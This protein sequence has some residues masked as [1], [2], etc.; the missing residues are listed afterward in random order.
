M[1][2]HIDDAY[3][4]GLPSE[5]AKMMAHLKKSVEVL[6]I[7]R[8][9]DHLGVSYSLQRDEIGWYYECEM[10]KY[11][12]KT[13]AEYEHDMKKTLQEHPTPAARGSILSKLGEEEAADRVDQFHKYIGRVLYAVLKVLLD[14]DN[15]IRD[16]TCHMT[17][18]GKEHWK[19]L[20]HL[21][22]YLKHHYRPMKF[23]APKELRAVA[24]FDG[25][26]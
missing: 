19:A 2:F 21:L 10:S 4:T 20:E 17:A 24:M 26:W 12:K 11:I 18:P 15:A 5:V 9:Q 13:I 23:R 6:E 16:M 3:C 14:C 7:G 25:D 1:V 22:G 8:M